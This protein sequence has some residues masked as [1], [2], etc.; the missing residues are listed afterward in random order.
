MRQS[1]PCPNFV[2]SNAHLDNGMEAQQEPCKDYS[3][4]MMR[5]SGF[6]SVPGEVL[7][8]S[9]NCKAAV[10]SQCPLGAHPP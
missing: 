5:P 3:P 10:P 6:L 1:C 4:F 9:C 7:S 8:D 2:N